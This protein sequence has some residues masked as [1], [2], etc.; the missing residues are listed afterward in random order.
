MR[1][2]R[3]NFVLDLADVDLV[4]AGVA[5]QHAE[6]TPVDVELLADLAVEEPADLL[7]HVRVAAG[8]RRA[9]SRSDGA[10]L[11][12][13]GDD[14]EDLRV[15]LLVVALN[16]WL[17]LDRA[18]ALVRYRPQ[19]FSSLDQEVVDVAVGASLRPQFALVALP[20][21]CHT[22]CSLR[23]SAVVR[24]AEVDVAQFVALSRPDS[25]LSTSSCGGL[26]R[27]FVCW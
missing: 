10:L 27:T 19:P 1:D 14:T 15:H 21:V 9:W 24:R 22:A 2:G 4:R 7:C 5:A 3:R 23:T 8:G 25:A 12:Q 6:K 26:T 13:Y 18:M 11:F 20:G 16:L 17:A